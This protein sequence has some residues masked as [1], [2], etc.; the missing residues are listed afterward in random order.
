MER[1]GVLNGVSLGGPLFPEPG[2]SALELGR[3]AA[4]LG[5]GVLAMGGALGGVAMEGATTLQQA[6]IFGFAGLLA[7]ALAAKAAVVIGPRAL[8]AVADMVVSRRSDAAVARLLPH[9]E[10]LVAAM[11]G[12]DGTVA[13]VDD[14][15]YLVW[16]EPGAEP[17]RMDRK[18]FVA[19]KREFDASGAPLV[20]VDAQARADRG[21]LIVCRYVH[22]RLDG[23]TAD[24][25][26]MVRLKANGG[27]VASYF[28]AGT[29][30]EARD[31]VLALPS[32][33]R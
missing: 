1:L 7:G 31:P 13:R 29:P 24:I 2:R 17:V 18:Q 10:I 25:P 4:S 22:G 19:W 11:G 30:V 15:G 26:A 16:R 28:D 8:K 27:T 9:A 33:G 6:G 5:I 12:P 20:V 14:A 21:E 3:A 32:P 23:A